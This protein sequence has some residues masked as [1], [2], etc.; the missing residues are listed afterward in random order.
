MVTEEQFNILKSI[1]DQHAKQLELIS[2]MI[3]N[4]VEAI[5]ELNKR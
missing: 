2:D 3:K 4:L 5:G 1:V